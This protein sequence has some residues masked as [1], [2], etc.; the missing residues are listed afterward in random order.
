MEN[1]RNFFLKLQTTNNNL[2]DKLVIF[3]LNKRI[4]Y[5][6][7]EF[8][9]VNQKLLSYKFP[10]MDLYCHRRRK[11]YEIGRVTTFP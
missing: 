6:E 10:L 8:T 7:A 3:K 1:V 9:R 11:M 5:K 2:S 4:K